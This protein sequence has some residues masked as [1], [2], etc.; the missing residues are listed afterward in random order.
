MY[1]GIDLG[2]SNSAI[3]GNDG[4]ELRVFKTVDGYDVLPSALMI[5]RRGATFVGKRA[6]EQDAFSPDDVGKRFKRLMGTT[7]PVTFKG[8]GRTMTPEQ[9]SSEILK[10]LLAQAR[11]AAGEFSLEGAIITIPAAFNQMQ[12]EA[13]MRAANAAGMECVG[14]LQ[15]PIAAAMA[16]IADRQRTNAA[17]KD[18]QFLVYDLGGG[19][20]DAAIVQS[21]GGTVNVVGHSGVNMLGGT[22][23]DRVLVNSLVRP[24]LLETFDLPEDFQKDKAYARILR[25]AAFYTERAKIEVSAQLTSTIHADENQIG[26]RDRAGREIFLDIPLSRTQVEMLITDQID[27]SIDVCRKLIA[28]SGY[29]SSDID[30]VVFIGGPTR[31]PYIRDRVPQQLGIAADLTTDPMTAVAV[32]AAIFSESRDWKGS[33]SES[34]KSRST[35]RAD[36]PVNIEYGYPERTADSRIRIRIRP[37]ADA[38]GKGYKLQVDS[39]MG[40]TSGQLALDTL[41]SIND[42]PLG[43]RGDNQFRVIVFDALGTP[44]PQAE[45]RFNVKR[46]DAAASGTPLTHTISVAVVEGTAGAVRNTLED[47]ITKGEPLPARGAKDFRAASDL[48]AGDTGNLDVN[49]YQGEPGVSDTKLVLHIGAFLIRASDLERGEVIRRGDQVRV[50]WALDENGLLDCELEVQGKGIGRRFKAGKMFSIQGAMKNFEGQEGEVLAKTALDTAQAELDELQRT[51][52]PR[53]AAEA[54]ELEER[55][56]RQRKDLNTSYEPDTRR[57]IAE[58]GRAIRQD[59]SKLKKR[60]EYIGDVLRD[61]IETLVEAFD[62][63]IRPNADPK[64]AERFNQLARQARESITRGSMEDAEKS[65]FEMRA[66]FFEEAFKQ[67]GFLVDIFMDLV[68][69]RHFAIDKSLHDRLVEAGKTSIERSDLSGLRAVIAQMHE[70]RYPMDAKDSATTALAGLMRW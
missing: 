6:Y 54:T 11:M 66:I 23:F 69:E 50:H 8:A 21:V 12:S 30:R 39:D 60:P 25:I 58:E 53:A 29:D 56:E 35:V 32:G 67:P 27:R 43:R 68:R 17:L 48:K 24:W 61:K 10:A 13:T 51:L 14:L 42:I 40:W 41:S 3:A 7:T 65:I 47:L 57:L 33:S 20:F 15:E 9:A 36:G 59:I 70:N 37:G 22:D 45:T 2:T 1:L 52:G 31:M 63:A 5:D 26:T 49:V 18:G 64:I 34:K 16:S 46:I 19:T 44:I 62:G 4:S 28:E 55:I 38:M